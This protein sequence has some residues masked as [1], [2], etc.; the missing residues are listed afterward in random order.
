MNFEQICNINNKLF[1]I[2]GAASG[3]GRETAI[4]LSSMGATLILVDCKNL[5]ETVC[6]CSSYVH[7]IICDITDEVELNR[8]LIETIKKTEQSV[9]GF[10]HFA[11]MSMIAPL[12]SINHDL[13]LNT[14]EINTIPAALLAKLCSSRNIVSQKGASFVLI[15]SVYGL[16]GSS[17]NI[18][19][20]M[21]KAA[22][23]GI[24]K[25]LAI[26]LASKNIRVNSVAPG[27]VKTDM[28]DS[29]A[30][31][32]GED[33]EDKLNDLHPLGLGAP[34][35]VALAVLYLISDMSRWVTGTILS[36]DGGFTA[37]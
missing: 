26:E 13:L 20:C 4:L 35:D 6:A 25:S 36:V 24:T 17:A 5:D 19:Y 14:L 12:K 29:I 10:V 3:L 7:E 22:L 28:F 34:M 37:R 31:N 21:S 11:G 9:D 32:F 18:A 33:Y 8:Q 2:T 30:S 23:H 1:I 15:S 16:V 27:F